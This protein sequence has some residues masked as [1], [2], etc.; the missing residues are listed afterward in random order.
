MLSHTDVFVLPSTAENLPMA[1]IEAF[2]FGIAVVATPVGAIPELIDHERNGLIVPVGDVKALADALRALIVDFELRGR[3]GNAAHRE[4]PEEIQCRS[5]CHSTGGD[6]ANSRA[7]ECAQS[8]AK[9]EFIVSMALLG[10]T[11]FG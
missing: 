6:L 11:W 2:A 9:K 3:L 8:L 4:P 10:C 1:I 5:V 7:G